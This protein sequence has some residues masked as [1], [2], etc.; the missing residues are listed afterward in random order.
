MADCSRQVAQ[1]GVAVA[2]MSML[3]SILLPVTPS[4][5]QAP[6]SDPTL[7]SS[8]LQPYLKQHTGKI[9]LATRISSSQPKQECLK[10]KDTLQ[11]S[12]PAAC[13]GRPLY[14]LSTSSLLQTS[15]VPWGWCREDAQ[16]SEG[17]WEFWCISLC[18]HLGN[19]NSC[20]DF[21]EC[22]THSP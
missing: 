17:F 19:S 8:F 16:I 2:S 15:N 3:A 14:Y 4:N 21:E 5:Q 18:I 11:H 6:Y 1:H 20:Y 7:Y 9:M 22:F 10:A 13:W 12:F